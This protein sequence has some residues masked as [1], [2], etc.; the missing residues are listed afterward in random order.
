MY[1]PTFRAY[2]AISMRNHRS[3]IKLFHGCAKRFIRGRR[4]RRCGEEP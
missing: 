1:F 2:N 3:T 4:D